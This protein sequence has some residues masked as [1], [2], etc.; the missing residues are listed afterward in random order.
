LVTCTAVGA[1][2]A[3]KVVARLKYDYRKTLKPGELEE[4]LLDTA[5]AQRH[6]K[7]KRAVPESGV[8]VKGIDNCLVRLARCCNPV[9]GD[10][11]TG[12]I[13]RGRGVSV[14][15]ANCLNVTRN[16]E[17]ENRIIEVSWYTAGNVAYNADIAIVAN[18]R[19]LLLME[20]TNIIGEAKIPLKAINARTTRNQ[21]AIINLTLEITDT[22]QLDMI[23]KRLKKI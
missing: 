9:P 11:I 20:I 19:T 3:T 15:R 17:D 13:T 14:H 4:E 2:A 10:D 8:V 5:V 6:E 12:D 16:L 22:D 23:I 21:L 7:K 1:I 18:D